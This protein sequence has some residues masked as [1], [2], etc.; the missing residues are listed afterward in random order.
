MR[1]TTKSLATLATAA[2]LA[3][4]MSG[5]AWADIPF[6]HAPCRA[7]WYCAA[8]YRAMTENCPDD[9]CCQR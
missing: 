8:Q 9:I 2:A 6:G 3:L 5:T 1:G 7:R 4:T